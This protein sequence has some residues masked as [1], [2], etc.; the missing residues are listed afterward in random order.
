[1]LVSAAG[2][3]VRFWEL[4]HGDPGQGLRPVGNALQ[5]SSPILSVALSPQGGTVL[6]SAADATAQLWSLDKPGEPEQILSGHLSGPVWQARFSPDGHQ[7]VTAGE[8]ESVRLWDNEGKELR[9]IEGHRGPVYAVEFSP[10][11]KFVVSGG[12]DR[13]ILVWDLQSAA[14]ATTRSET[15]ANR[16]ASRSELAQSSG[17][18]QLGEHGAPIRSISF[19]PDG[20]IVFSASQDNS[21]CVWDVGQG[22]AQGKLEKTLR[23]HGGWVRTCAAAADGRHVLSGSYDGRVHLWDWQNY[24]FPRVLRP[25]SERSLSDMRFTSAAVSPDAN[26]IATAAESGAV[27]MWDM[28]DPLNPV[29]QL[30]T[31]GHDWQ[32]TTAAYF[33]SGRRLLTAG[34]DNSTLVWDTERGNQ[35]VRIGGWNV[36]G[37]SG[38]R[39]V[40]AASHQGHWI[41]TGSDESAVLARL[42]DA[43]TGELVVA[44]T[45]PGDE[46]AARGE[47]SEATAIAFGPEDATLFVGDQWG[48]CRL[49]RISDGALLKSFSGHAGKISGAAFLPDGRLLTASSDGRVAKWDVNADQPISQAE[50]ELPHGGRVVAMDVSSDGKLVVTATDSEDSEAVLRVWN[51]GSGELIHDLSLNEVT[52]VREFLDQSGANEKRV[53]IRSVSMHPNQ[54]RVLVTVFAPNSSTYQVGDWRW[55][56]GSNSIELVSTRLRDTSMAVYAPDRDG[57]VL[58][59][60][61]RGARLRLANQV[62]MSY[63]PQLGVLSVAFSPNSRS[64]ACAGS[65]GS[66][67]LWRN[68]AA[69]SRW[70]PEQKLTG[71]HV[72]A[73]NSVAFHP[74]Q[75]DSLLTAGGDGV[76]RLWHRDANGWSVVASLGEKGRQE[77]VRQAI[78][79]SPGENESVEILTAS[80]DDKEFHVRTWSLDG[81]LLGKP[82]THP[83]R[84]QCIAVSPDQK[85]FV[86]GVGSEVWVWD[87]AAAQGDPKHKLR[88]HSAEVASLAFS[89]DGMR[90]FTGSRDFNVK[91]WDTKP[92]QAAA[93]DGTQSSSRELLTLEGHTDGVTSLSFLQSPNYPSLLTAGADGQAILW[94]SVDWQQ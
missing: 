71:G 41:A 1:M 56:S 20:N 17:V 73:V 51:S 37:G 5:Y 12:R 33:N 10:D 38:W 89:P 16:L 3:V 72:G 36:A 26:W 52:G 92:W 47:G 68:D 34:G 29:S 58:T 90:L 21:V 9:K 14:E 4:P 55:D 54:P 84:T 27:T 63:R 49:F 46:Q 77:S 6:T 42:W 59:V 18:V 85:W 82:L 86:S 30:L 24:E 35:L 81:E 76:A 61:G 32:A 93:M 70:L 60:G 83:G 15:I 80:N 94:P 40:A 23:G 2:K 65:D 44:L 50:L 69:T 53:S 87:R 66:I 74:L 8:D 39:G 75:D 19:A 78:F 43:D 48:N 11:G 31:E 45:T 62:V 28:R 67:K 13:R 25:E 88:G 57:G 64:L 7:I 22:L 91:L 79:T